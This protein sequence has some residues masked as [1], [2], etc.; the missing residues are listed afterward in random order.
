MSGRPTRTSPIVRAGPVPVGA[1]T[2]LVTILAVFLAYNA[3]TGLPFATTYEL[4]AQVPNADALFRGNE[5]RVGGV[6]VGRIDA[7]TP[8]TL[9]D[10]REVANIEM[11]LDTTV[12]PLPADSTMVVRPRSPLALKYL[13]ITPGD[14]ERGLPAGATIPV[15][16]AKPEPVDLDEL[17]NTFDAKTRK[18]TRGNLEGFGD[19]LAGRGSDLNAAFA[20]LRPLF[21]VAEPAT[22]NLADPETDFDGFWDRLAA[23][24]AEVA[25]VATTQAELFGSLDRTFAAFAEV[26]RPYI[27]ET[28]ERSPPT[29]E[30]GT[31][32]LPKMRPFLRHMAEFFD[33]LEPGA[34]TLAETSPVIADA[35]T[36]GARVLP[37]TPELNRELPGIARALLDFQEAPGVLAGLD[38]IR[39]TNR[40]LRPT[41]AD[42]TPAQA[43][44]NYL[45]IL[46]E[47]AGNTGEAGNALGK[48]QRF[49]A[50]GPVADDDNEDRTFVPFT[51][52]NESMQ[53]AAPADGPDR[54]NHLHYNA[55]PNTAAPGQQLECE[56]GNDSLRAYA[57]GETVIGNVDGNQGLETRG[58][59]RQAAR[60]ER[61]GS[62]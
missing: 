59:A 26:A 55:Y 25:P 47:N 35:L 38:R 58:N 19:A 48:W 16:Q 39:K 20:A 45:T 3:N 24:A 49:V 21:E 28:I 50:L 56:A 15:A 2:V 7:V 14:S 51:P 4:N 8:V 40:I 29:L 27:E 46:F 32:S 30:E 9:E 62:G 13:E 23:T 60:A 36:T 34:R 44:C 54:A 22:A 37:R 43:T 42:I 33:A 5:V 10:G 6:R 12:E 53:A 11:T 52:N 31:R 17:F 1:V 41:L 61:R 57:Q 18:G